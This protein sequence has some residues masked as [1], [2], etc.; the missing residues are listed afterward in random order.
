MAHQPARVVPASEETFSRSVVVFVEWY[1]TTRHFTADED[2]YDAVSD[3]E[4]RRGIRTHTIE[5]GAPFFDVFAR[6][7]DGDGDDCGSWGQGVLFITDDEQRVLY[8]PP[9]PNEFGNRTRDEDT[10][11]REMFLRRVSTE[12]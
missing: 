8:N 10:R 12:W 9:Y 11:R 5:K 6:F 2:G 4:H 3:V 7:E 1:S